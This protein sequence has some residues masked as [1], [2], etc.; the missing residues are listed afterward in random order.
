M[1]REVIIAGKKLKLTNLEKLMWPRDTINKAGLIKYYADISDIVL[2]HLKD[3][4]FIMSR[5]PD[6]I[7]GK[8]FYQKECP[9]YAPEWVRTFPVKSPDVGKTIN[10]IICN[11]LPTLLWLANQAC[12]ELHIWLAKVPET[13]C[14]DIMVFDLD[15][16]YPATFN[17]TLKVALLVKE[18][19]E[20]FGLHGY[21]K[22]SG[23]TG[24]HVFVPIKPEYTYSEVR[25]GVEFIC[26][27]VNAVLPEKTTMERLVVNR[28]GKV[29]LDY[30]QNTQGKTMTFQY[31]L[32]PLPGAPVSA[33]LTWDEV[34]QGVVRPGDFNSFNIIDR[35]SCVGD[36]YA[37]F[38]K[39]GQS[40]QKLMALVQ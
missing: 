35:I 6:G 27:H 7:D 12:I 26:R 32:R 11:D 16:M 9:G 28:N 3:R 30:L 18:A 14:P 38:L 2:P 19:L 1:D 10:Y 20:Q 39:P 17:D 5:Y 24:L 4:L 22:T 21:P 36:L 34:R 23:A 37:D 29:Y 31:S 40:L 13:N 33:P 15:P 8:M 25:A